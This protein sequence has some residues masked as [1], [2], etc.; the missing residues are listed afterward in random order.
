M[1]FSGQLTDLATDITQFSTQQQELDG[2]RIPRT[3][4]FS[5]QGFTGKAVLRAERL[6][7]EGQ[8]SK[9]VA[10]LESTPPAPA[11]EETYQQLLA[12]HPIPDTPVR[13]AIPPRTPSNTYIPADKAFLSAIK[14]A[15]SRVRS[16]LTNWTYDMLKGALSTDPSSDMSAIKDILTKFCT[17]LFI[18]TPFTFL[19]LLGC[20]L[21]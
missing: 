19:D 18:L 9:A 12:L 8:V 1:F 7:K 4:V 10:A 21:L 20:L 6:A 5:E 17:G 2:I 13:S 15:P 14:N 11:T 3:H 16:G